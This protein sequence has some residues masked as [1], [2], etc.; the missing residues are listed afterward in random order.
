[1][2]NVKWGVLGAGWLVN[3]ATAAA[4]HNAH[5]AE[6]YAT[7][8]R[9]FERAKA[10]EP[11]VAY[12]EYQAVIHDPRV[13]AVYI[14]LANDAHVPWIHA[15]LDAGKHVLC[16][17]PMAMSASDAQEAFDHAQRADLLLV[18]A[19]WSRWHPR[20]RRIVQLVT[21]GHLGEIEEYEGSFTFQ[22]VAAD[23]YRL[24]PQH[25]GGALYDVGIYPLHGLFAILPGVD[26]L[27][28][29]DVQRERNDAG[30]DL[31]TKAHLTW[32]P[33]TRA[34]ITASF[35][36]DPQQDLCIR[37]TDGEVRV[38]DNEAWATWRQPTSL[39]VDGHIEEFPEVDAYQ[40]MFEG[41]SEAITTGGGW[42][43]PPRDSL[44]VARAVDSLL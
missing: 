8:A 17:K 40:L 23:N 7:A 13:D 43:L 30:V 21:E 6:L 27:T 26:A 42:V 28:V 37:G 29:V 9:D 32:G 14:C 12:S 35:V 3:Q 2:T 41:V 18:E 1:M 31:T 16:E 36:M 11:V 22:G 20:I 5:G 4:I 44:R 25:G 39:W 24:L 15:A 38:Q 33:E 34:H 10:T 19:T